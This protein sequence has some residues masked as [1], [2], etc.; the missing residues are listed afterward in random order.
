METSAT[1]PLQQQSLLQDAVRP[2]KARWLVFLARYSR[3]FF[4]VLGA[5]I[6]IGFV[7]IGTF[8]PWIAP[9]E[10]N[11]Q[12]LN[13]AEIAP[14]LDH[15][16]G[17]DR[18]GRDQFSRMIWATRTALFVAPTS[19]ILGLFIGVLLGAVAGYMG[20][21][22]DAVIMRIADVLFA[23][24]GLLFALFVAATIGPRIQDWLR[25][26]EFL[27]EFVRGGLAEYVIVVVALS[28][29]GWPGLARLVRGQMLKLREEPYVEAAYVM[30]ATPWW[31][32]TR[33]LLP[34]A[35]PPVIVAVSLGLGGAVLAESTLSFFGIGIQPPVASWGQMLYSNFEFWRQ[36][37]AIWLVWTP[38]LA[39]AL[40]VFA[41][42]FIGDGLLE[43]LDPRD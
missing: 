25:Q 18:L 5:F 2:Q 30:G 8:A 3:N 33:H 32:L 19:V 39:V 9:Y 38:G 40:M 21:W 10:Y 36:N 14:G 42:N 13:R 23:F 24:P 4:A 28:I 41:F 11:E 26:F 7:F 20:G 17:T 22:V 43:A 16:L 31:I 29:V 15:P 37:S 35:M 12:D 34:N 6:V 1:L 27:E